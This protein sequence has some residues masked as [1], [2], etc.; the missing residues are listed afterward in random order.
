MT[1]EPRDMQ[2][3]VKLFTLYGLTDIKAAAQQSG[4]A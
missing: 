1:D 2:F 4:T 3:E